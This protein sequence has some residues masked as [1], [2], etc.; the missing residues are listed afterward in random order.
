MA[1]IGVVLGLKAQV[2]PPLSERAMTDCFADIADGEVHRPSL[3]VA[4][5]CR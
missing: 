3:L 5:E 4:A 1:L 2:A